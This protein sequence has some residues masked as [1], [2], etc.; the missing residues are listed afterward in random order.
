VATG[1]TPEPPGG[2]PRPEP[3]QTNC[4][5]FLDRN[6]VVRD[7]DQGLIDFPGRRDGREIYLCWRLGEE[8]VDFWH[9]KETGFPGRQPL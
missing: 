1:G 5:A 3:W 6:I 2:S 8:S 9:D 4:P 7:V